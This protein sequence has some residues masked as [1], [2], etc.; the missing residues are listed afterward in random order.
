MALCKRKHTS[1]LFLFSGSKIQTFT[2]S[3]EVILSA[4][5]IG[6]PSILLHSGIGD[7]NELEPLSIP[8]VL[9][10]PSVGRNLSDQPF[11]ILAWTSTSTDP[12]DP[13]VLK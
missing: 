7:A 6:T 8:S 3:K 12:L 2:A 4:G 5:S 9:N 1:F 13:Y 10:L 11:A